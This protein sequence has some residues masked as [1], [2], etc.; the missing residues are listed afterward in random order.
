MFT[1]SLTLDPKVFC[2][3]LDFYGYVVKV[4]RG[5]PYDNCQAIRLF[6]AMP[7]NHCER[8]QRLLEQGTRRAISHLIEDAIYHE[9]GNLLTAI[10]TNKHVVML[11]H[12]IINE[13]PSGHFIFEFIKGLK[14][15]NLDQE[16]YQEMCEL[17]RSRIQFLKFQPI[18]K[19]PFPPKIEQAIH[20]FF[21]EKRAQSSYRG[22][23]ALN[24]N[25]PIL[26]PDDDLGDFVII[27]KQT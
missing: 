1:F 20:A 15:A 6:D 16:I 10:L 11:S 5:M 7:P 12:E 21:V 26:C 3:L 22:L 27:N 13:S 23:S 17:A 9:Q 19:E 18:E 24:N 25:E 14:A 4:T 2:N 8:F